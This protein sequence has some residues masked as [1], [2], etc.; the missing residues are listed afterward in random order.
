M[1]TL[2]AGAG[3]LRILRGAHHPGRSGRLEQFSQ[4]GK[5]IG[6]EASGGTVIG[7]RKKELGMND[8]EIEKTGEEP[9]SATQSPVMEKKNEKSDGVA[10]SPEIEIAPAATAAEQEASDAAILRESRKHTRRS[11]VV[12][13]V[14]AAAGFGVYQWIGSSDIEGRQPKPFRRAFQTNANVSR[15]VFDD[16]ALAPTYSVNRAEDL[17]VNGVYGLK[18]A[19]VPESWRLQLVGA[20]NA[21]T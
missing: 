18:E 1:G 2:L 12:A 16:R 4:H 17:R 21:G 7:G 5:R 20:A 9:T 19:L 13:A 6:S 11:F 14:G 8:P 3:I 15:T 10:L